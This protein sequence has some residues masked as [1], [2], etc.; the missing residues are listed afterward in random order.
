MIYIVN[1]WGEESQGSWVRDYLDGVHRGLSG[2]CISHKELSN[3]FSNE[4]MK[5]L[6]A[7]PE[8]SIVWF[9]VYENEFAGILRKRRP[10]LKLVA[11]AHGTKTM[12]LEP[13]YIHNAQV[14]EDKPEVIEAKYED[15]YDLL[16]CNSEYQK[17][18]MTHKDKAVVTGFPLDLDLYSYKLPS[19]S[20]FVSKSVVISQRFSM[21]KN[22][23]IA[24]WFCRLLIDKGY[25]VIWCYGA[26]TGDFE[27]LSDYVEQAKQMG[28]LMKYNKTKADYYDTL[29]H[30]EYVLT[31][32]LYDTLS[33]SMVEGALA[34][35][36]VVAPSMMCFPEYMLETNMYEPFSGKD[37][38]RA[39][40]TAQV[41]EL[42][43]CSDGNRLYDS[44]V[45]VWNMIEAMYKKGFII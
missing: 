20:E 29:G 14:F 4:L 21:E 12:W 19:H 43:F 23:P 33:L 42:G 18:F 5:E 24:L 39:M 34:G 15:V 31:T 44:K 13:S 25:S 9:T 16:F 45:V 17:S 8:N 27:L 6:L 7:L 30:C 1:P 10:D 22:L 3:K 41:G 38:L 40:D 2:M 32:S 26:K 28:V 11:H 36:R 37:L 35:C